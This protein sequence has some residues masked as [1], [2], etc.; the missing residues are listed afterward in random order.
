VHW[1]TRVQ[2][3]PPTFER[4]GGQYKYSKAFKEIVE[5]CLV[6]DPARRP[7]AA[8]LLETPFFKSSKKKSYLVGAILSE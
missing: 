4:Q 1:F 7:T 2:D 6:K 5:S 8:Q 3:A